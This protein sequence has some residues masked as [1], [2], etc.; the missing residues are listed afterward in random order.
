[1]TK[2][3]TAA[4]VLA[5]AGAASAAQFQFLAVAAGGNGAQPGVNGAGFT[6][7]GGTFYQDGFGANTASGIN[8]AF[9]GL[10]PTLE[11]DTYSSI[12]AVGPA[13]GGA[14]ALSRGFYGD[15]VGDTTNAGGTLTEAPGG[16]SSGAAMYFGL[17]VSPQPFLSGK[18]PNMG[19]GRSNDDGVFLG[20]FTVSGGGSVAGGAE[21]S[22]KDVGDPATYQGNVAVGGPAVQIGA[23]QY[24]LKAFVV[25]DVAQ[26]R[27]HDLW[28]VQIPTPGALAL[29]GLG[30]VAAIRR[31]RA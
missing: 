19:G 27:V 13:V 8:P 24:I 26:G 16:T 12:S 10:V 11:F 20:R 5:I 30:G 2:L 23:A 9:M 3:L 15:L 29:F 18:A 14:A 31:R 25:G 6:P 4:S 17:G 1:M 7:V 21:V 22:L 28:L